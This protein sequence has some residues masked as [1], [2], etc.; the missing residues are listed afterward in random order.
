M[1]LFHN[2]CYKTCN[3]CNKCCCS[4]KYQSNKDCKNYYSIPVINRHL[5]YISNKDN[6][7]QPYMPVTTWYDEKIL[8]QQL[9]DLSHR[10]HGS[11]STHHHIPSSTHHH[12][13]SYH[14]QHHKVNSGCGCGK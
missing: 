10:H 4:C 5:G 7:S 6:R 13:P 1:N 8:Q 3:P 2:S 12:G 9:H 14:H 11:S